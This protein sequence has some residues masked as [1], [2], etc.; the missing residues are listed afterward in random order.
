MEFGNPYVANFW[1]GVSWALGVAVFVLY[2]VVSLYKNDINKRI[3]EIITIT[4]ALNEQMKKFNEGRQKIID[5]LASII[6]LL[7]QQQEDSERKYGRR[8]EDHPA[9]DDEDK[10]I[11]D[12]LKKI[13]QKQRSNLDRY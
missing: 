2:S 4:E 9:A 5:M 7:P 3:A 12:L 6:D 1:M 10:E 11:I 13:K 8:K